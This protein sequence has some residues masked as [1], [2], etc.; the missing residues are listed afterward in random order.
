MPKQQSKVE[1]PTKQF[2]PEQKSICLELLKQY[3]QNRSAKLRNQ[4]VQMNIGLVKKEVTYWLHQSV[5]T[6]EDLL[7]VGAIGLIGAI[8]RFEMDKGYAFSSFAT[9][10]IRGEIQHYLRDKRHILR[11]PRRWQEL[12]DQAYRLARQLRADLGREPLDRELAAALHISELEWSEVKLA[13]QN[14]SPVSLD[15]PLSH[16]DLDSDCL[17]ELMAD[18]K[19]WDQFGHEEGIRLNQALT[20]LD[21]KTREI[22]EYVFLEDITQREVAKIYGVSAVTISR[23]VKKGLSTLRSLLVEAA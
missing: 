14:R 20:C 6:Y 22:V 19:S 4:I 13:Y 9:R 10:Y 5:E 11:I 23:Q 7:Q 15:A 16:Q 12:H 1:P 3:Q 21:P 2:S 17:L 8:D 18:P